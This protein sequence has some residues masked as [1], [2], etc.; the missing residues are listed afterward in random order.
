MD[1]RAGGQHSRGWSTAVRSILPTTGLIVE[2]FAVGESVE[3]Q[4]FARRDR[5]AP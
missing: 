5:V 1:G 3:A 2:H 4:D